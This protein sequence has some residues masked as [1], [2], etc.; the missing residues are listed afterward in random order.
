MKLYLLLFIGILVASCSNSDRN[1]EA[2]LQELYTVLDSEIANSDYY[3]KIKNTRIADYKREYD[4]SSDRHHRTA[5]VNRLINE[6]DSYTADSA[7]FY[8]GYNLRRPA[9]TA[10]PGEM[11]RQ[12]IRRADVQAHA[13]LFSDALATL[14]AVNRDSMDESMLENYFATYCSLYQY[15]SEFVS[16]REAS[17]KYEAL[18]G[19][20]TDSLARVAKPESFNF[21]KFVVVEQSRR[22]DAQEA[23]EQLTA[24]LDEYPSGSRE[25]SILASSLAFIY[26]QEGNEDQ[27][28]RHLVLS[29]ISDLRGAVKEN[30]SFRELAKVMFEDGDIERANRYLKKS[31]TDANFYSSLLRNVQSSRM[32][33]VIDEAYSQQQAG[34]VNRQRIL[35]VISVVLSV[36]L[37]GSI[38]WILKQYRSLHRAKSQVEHANEELSLLSDRLKAANAELKERNLEL[39][40]YNRTKEEYAGLFMEF[41]STA[42]SNLEHYQ[43]TLRNLIAQGASKTILIKKFESY[44]MADHLL[45]NFY[46]KFD[47]AILNIYPSFIH[48]INALLRPEE[49][50]VLTDEL[51]N[52]ELR[53]L[54]LIRIG[55]EDSS[56]IAKFLRCSL[57]TV[58]TYRSKMKKRAVDPANFERDLKKIV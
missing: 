21:K 16:D 39:H 3:D 24:Y 38:I 9:V 36:I 55:I 23:I 50:I 29:A 8:I 51:L 6:Y 31:I 15:L 40:E 44:E 5:I 10:V 14:E 1:G 33:P 25:Y 47:E 58:Y 30:M 43:A 48:K 20:Y 26:D 46:A 11:T 34:L 27:Y 53:V 17:E 37:L 2:E 18:R 42:I 56:Q 54:A 32:L 41:C 12:L 7:L 57:A 45:K 22:G 13:G 35:V 52:T 4:L 28:K 49:Q 19:A